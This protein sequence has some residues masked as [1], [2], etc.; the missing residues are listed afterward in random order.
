[1]EAA[2][3]ADLRIISLLRGG[4]PAPSVV[5]TGAIAAFADPAAPLEAFVSGDRRRLRRQ[6]DPYSGGRV[7]AQFI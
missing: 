1:M 6:N 2:K 5:E 7:A 4:S 3:P